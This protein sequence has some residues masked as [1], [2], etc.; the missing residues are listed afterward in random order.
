MP[1]RAIDSRKVVA[2]L[3]DGIHLHFV[4]LS[5]KDAVT[6]IDNDS[7]I[8]LAFVTNTGNGSRDRNKGTSIATWKSEGG[9]SPGVGRVAKTIVSPMATREMK[10][11]D[12]H[13]QHI[14]H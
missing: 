1:A 14:M 8:T 7:I 6:N 10:L 5:V 12:L 2:H 3:E 13:L 4:L 11:T 9:G